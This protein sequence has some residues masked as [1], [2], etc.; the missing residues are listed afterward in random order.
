VYYSLWILKGDV[1]PTF[2]LWESAATFRLDEV[3]KSCRESAIGNFRDIFEREGLSYFLNRG[4]DHGLV[5]VMLK[6][7]D[8]RPCK[9]P[10]EV[11]RQMRETQQ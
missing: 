6:L 11:L 10:E 9:A 5:T 3:E 4:I 8:K 7:S 2:D 1:S